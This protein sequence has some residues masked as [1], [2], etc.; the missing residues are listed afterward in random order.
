[1]II[2]GLVLVVVV[3]GGFIYN[4]FDG[5]NLDELTKEQVIMKGINTFVDYVHFSPHEMDDAYAE[6]VFHIYLE[7]L[8]G[9]KQFFTGEE[10]DQLKTNLDQLDDQIRSFDL[11]FFNQS[12]DIYKNAFD[13]AEAF[14]VSILKEP[15]D[16]D[17]DENLERDPEKL[18]FARDTAALKDYWRKLL[19]YE[20]VSRIID[21][22]NAKL[23]EDEAQTFEEIEKEAREGTKK[24]YDRY[25]DRMKD[26]LREQ[27]LFDQYM[28]AITMANDP[29]S[30][31]F[32]P[33]KKEDFEIDMSGK[34]EGIGA[35]LTKDGEYTKV[36]SIVPGGPAWKGKELEAKDLIAKVAQGDEEPVDVRGWRT[37]D[38]VQLIRGEAGTT[39]RLFVKKPDGTMEEVAIIRDEVEIG[40]S[41]AK[42]F[43]IDDEEINRKIGYIKLPRFYF[44]FDGD[45]RSSTDMAEELEKMK[46]ENVEGVILDLRFNPGGSLS[47]VVDISGLF[48]EGGP[49][50]QVKSRKDDPYIWKDKDKKSH[51]DGPLVILVNHFSASASEILAAAMQ[52]YNRAVI[53]GSTSTFGKGTVQRFFQLDQAF[54]G[55]NPY[56]NLGD[57]KLTIQKYYRINGGSVQ[58]RGVIPD[59]ILPDTYMYMEM[60]EKDYDN[61]LE[62]TKIDPLKYNQDVFNIANMDVI[63]ANS[64]Q[65]VEG[66]PIFSKI[67]EYAKY[68]K[69]VRNQSITPLD[70]EELKA[71]EKKRKSR[72]DKFNDLDQVNEQIKVY[73]Y[74][75]DLEKIQIDSSLIA[76]NQEEMSDIQKDVYINEALWIVN[77]LIES[78]P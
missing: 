65:R 58:L 30:N 38:V 70:L 63:K 1:M 60:G 61:P 51:Y 31:Y 50:V 69:E 76:A 24:M 12:Y 59:I 15:F 28:N 26:F 11:T 3:L 44:E 19:K 78:Q 23:E 77:D 49:I 10:V 75:K 5:E 37:D 39:V 68:L 18:D 27:D 42:S 7:S 64:K 40:Q 9:R 16:Y 55:N 2:R 62:W 36:V 56:G 21:K 8:D 20:T 34:L 67:D 52:D 72:S 54:R 66:N 45:K 73:N 29:H 14:Y 53:V 47:D 46:D 41:F 6:E 48:I 25:F 35:R 57:V 74:P 13:R 17:V 32:S 4:Q 33:K 22:Q 71:L 43:I